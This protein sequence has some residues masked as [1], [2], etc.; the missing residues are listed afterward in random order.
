MMY[1]FQIKHTLLTMVQVCII[2]SSRVVCVL[3]QVWST[4]YHMAF[5]IEV[6]ET[7]HCGDDTLT[8]S[9]LSRVII[10]NIAR[11]QSGR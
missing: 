3:L 1:P 6:E 9:L 7:K 5:E 10:K 2:I 4:P 11:S 8:N